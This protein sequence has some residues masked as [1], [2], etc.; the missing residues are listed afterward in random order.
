MGALQLAWVLLASRSD[1]L[2]GQSFS[3]PPPPLPPSACRLPSFSAQQLGTLLWGLGRMRAPV[4]SGWLA[5]AV[6]TATV[7]LPAGAQGAD[8]GRL[9]GGLGRLHPQLPRERFDPAAASTGLAGGTAGGPAGGGGD[10][11]GQG[12]SGLALWAADHGSQVAALLEAAAPLLSHCSGRELSSAAQGAAALA[13]AAPPPAFVSA[14]AAAVDA[15]A[16]EG[17]GGNDVAAARA[18]LQQLQA[19]R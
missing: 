15:A 10:G 6:A 18:A 1:A 4:P 7:Q 13:L 9:L 19:G 12:V 14:L 8:V 11:P 5:A 3:T 16:G 2:P 17:G